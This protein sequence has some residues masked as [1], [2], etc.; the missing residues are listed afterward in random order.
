MNRDGTDQ[1]QLTTV[2]GNPVWSPN[3]SKIAFASNVTGCSGGGCFAIYT[4]NPDGS[5]QT[6]LTPAGDGGAAWS[7]DGSKIAFLS[8]RD[9]GRLEIYTMNADGS[10]QTRLT[11]N[12]LSDWNPIWSP[13]GTKIAF[14]RT[15][16][17][18]FEEWIYVMNAD[19]GGERR[20]APGE[21]V[22]DWQP[23]A[24]PKRSDYKNAA[25]FCK[26]E[27]DFMGVSAFRQKYGPKN[28]GANAFGKCVSQNH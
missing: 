5:D 1:T 4:M 15:D 22:P 28:K 6:R 16:E 24:G 10:N 23:L 2:G 8:P 20:L 21:L 7:P 11:Y 18:P 17:P 12:S 19:G 25:T 27:R 3:G 14:V 9:G 26:A 13:D